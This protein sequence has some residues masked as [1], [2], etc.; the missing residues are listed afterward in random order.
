MIDSAPDR[1]DDLYYRRFYGKNGA[2]DRARIGHLAA[3]VHHLAAWWGVRIK[4]VLDVGSGMGMWR[5]WYV[6]NHPKTRVVST[7]ISE[8]ACARW[9]HLQRDISQWRPEG[10]FDLVICHSVLQYLENP[11]AAT[12]IENLAAATNSLLYLEAPT[13]R[14]FDTIID[15]SATDMDVH[16]RSGDWYRRR[17]GVHFI[18]IGAGLWVRRGSVPMYELEASR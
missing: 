11:K 13:R 14:D 18:Q 6:E 3:A 12:A 10:H 7:D 2:H 17:L 16:I 9:G 8:H 5:D 1:F 15:P 4:S